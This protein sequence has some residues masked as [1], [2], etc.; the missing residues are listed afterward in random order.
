[1]LDVDN[2]VVPYRSASRVRRRIVEAS[3]ITLCTTV[4]DT[5]ATSCVR[6]MD[7]IGPIVLESVPFNWK[8]LAAAHPTMPC[9]AVPRVYQK[10]FSTNDPTAITIGDPAPQTVLSSPRYN[11]RPRNSVVMWGSPRNFHKS[12][13]PVWLASYVRICLYTPSA[14]MSDLCRLPSDF[15]S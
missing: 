11:L 14:H 5:K 7:D 10:F 12:S 6:D 13:A 3:L 9:H 4:A 2:A 15:I 1:M 8:Q